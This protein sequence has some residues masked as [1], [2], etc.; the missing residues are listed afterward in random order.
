MDNRN[1]KTERI[2][3]I[4]SKFDFFIKVEV[5]GDSKVGKTALLKQ[6]I[7]NEFDEEYI[8]TYGYEFN[9]YISK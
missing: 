2:R 8:P 6:L 5:V 3:N 4:N 1:Y 7:N 9:I